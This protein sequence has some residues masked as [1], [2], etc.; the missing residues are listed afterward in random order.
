MPRPFQPD[1]E[2][3]AEVSPT[4]AS[5]QVCSIHSRDPVFRKA[6]FLQGLSNAEQ[7]DIVQAARSQRYAVN[8]VV[9]EQG[10]RADRLF[11]LLKGSARY[12]F[13]TPEGRKVNLYW[14][15]PGDIF[16]GACLL[17]EPAHFVVS[18]EV[19]KESYAVWRRE[20]LQTLA[21]RYPRLME[22]ALSIASDYL[23]WYLATHLSLICHSARE[24]VAHVLLSL[25]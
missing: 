16:G 13:I 9:Q 8:S 24:R 11:L 4:F 14:L 2:P 18:T 23:V 22:N 25:I 7:N 3:V 17:P 15:V 10:N 12:F 5:V 19:A 21:T 20:T 1:S 6:R